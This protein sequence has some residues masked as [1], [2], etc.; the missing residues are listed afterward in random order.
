MDVPVL[1]LG[2]HSYHFG[3]SAGMGDAANL[4][5]PDHTGNFST[6][7]CLHMGKLSHTLWW[8]EAISLPYIPVTLT[9]DGNKPQTF[10]G[11]W[12]TAVMNQ[13]AMKAGFKNSVS[14][15]S[16]EDVVYWI[17]LRSL[18][19]KES[20]A[21]LFHLPSALWG[22]HTPH[23]RCCLIPTVQERTYYN[24]PFFLCIK[25]NRRNSTDN[26]L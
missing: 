14:D 26:F 12:F 20:Q 6:T 3:I 4:S 22:K 1:H 5:V 25:T 11:T 18:L 24:Y 21:M 23:S 7:K 2:N 13:K 15:A 19:R 9:H 10:S 17:S 16:Q 8:H